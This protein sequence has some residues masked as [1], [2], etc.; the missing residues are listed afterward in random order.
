MWTGYNY[1]GAGRAFTGTWTA[2]DAVTWDHF[3]AFQDDIRSIKNNATGG[4]SI[5]DRNPNYEYTY[6]W[7]YDLVPNAYSRGFPTRAQGRRPCTTQ[8]HLH[9]LRLRTETDL[10]VRPPM[11]I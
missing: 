2:C 5:W 8:L 9:R 11:T 7:L 6:D 10:T 1:T 4:V 3:P